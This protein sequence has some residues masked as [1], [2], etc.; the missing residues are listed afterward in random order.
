MATASRIS[1]SARHTTN[2]SALSGLLCCPDD[3]EALMCAGPR[4]DC[5]ACGR[6]FPVHEDGVIE[7]LPRRAAKLS[8][9][10]N[11]AYWQGY[12]EEFRK[13]YRANP[14]AIAWGAPEAHTGKWMRKRLR[15]VEALRPLVVE[16]GP[17]RDHVFCDIAAGA[18]NYTLSY[19]R[20]FKSVL[21]CDLSVDNLNYAVRKARNLG[22]ENIFFLRMDYF[23]PPF[24]KSLDRVVCLDTLIRGE[25]HEIALLS[26]I[27]RSLR[28]EGRAVVDFHNWWHNPLRRIGLL[29]ENFAGNRSYR[30]KDAERLL[31]TAGLSRFGRFPVHQE[32]EHAGRRRLLSYALPS[33]RL[34]YRFGSTSNLNRIAA[35]EFEATPEAAPCG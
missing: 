5:D 7:L 10:E 25:R 4:I 14:D 24:Y 20:H 11:G 15:Q 19:A 12:F 27:E 2:T 22:I 9:D 35:S 1:A 3:G 31:R 6:N 23:S 29:P 21:H 18:G 26:A 17:G 16:G 30:R 33:T 32:F 28:P 34:V 8:D 13:P